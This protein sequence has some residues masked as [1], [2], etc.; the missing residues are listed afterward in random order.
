MDSHIIEK[1][2]IISPVIANVSALVLFCVMCL[3]ELIIP[4]ETKAIL[5]PVSQD[6]NLFWLVILLWGL[7]AAAWALKPAQTL[8]PLTRALV[9]LHV[10][11]SLQAYWIKKKTFL[12]CFAGV[13]NNGNTYDLF[14]FSSD[15][16]TCLEVGTLPH[17]TCPHI[18]WMFLVQSQIWILPFRS[19][20]ISINEW[21]FFLFNSKFNSNWTEQRQLVQQACQS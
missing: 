13:T 15:H 8:S 3:G 4:K 7:F 11:V 19:R 1:D 5:F 14:D 2:S 6:A 21:L 10:Q 12:C 9:S 16:L 18:L 17:K 20:K